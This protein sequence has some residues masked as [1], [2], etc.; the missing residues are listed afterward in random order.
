MANYILKFEGNWADE[1]DVGGFTFED[2]PMIDW[3]LET[4]DKA[5][6][7]YFS[8]YIGSNQELTLDRYD[9]K[10]GLSESE[11]PDEDFEVL[12]KYK[13]LFDQ[14]YSV[15]DRILEYISQLERDLIADE[16]KA[17]LYSGLDVEKYSTLFSLLQDYDTAYKYYKAN[18]LE[19]NNKFFSEEWDRIQTANEKLYDDKVVPYYESVTKYTKDLGFKVF[20]PQKG[21]FINE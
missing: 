5:G 11:V 10:S 17:W 21:H 14:S 1:M 4:L 8:I 3:I 7:S 15:L 12:I 18:K 9:L 2:G 6:E 19:N 20:T 16:E 13:Y